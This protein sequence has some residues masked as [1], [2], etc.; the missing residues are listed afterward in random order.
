[1]TG[2]PG[3]SEVQAVRTE[4]HNLRTELRNLIAALPGHPALLGQADMQRDE[5]AE[6]EFIKALDQR[7]Q[8]ARRG[9]R[10]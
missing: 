10:R 5:E 4:L 1:M 3:A 6:E 8:A 2:S 7:S 9:K